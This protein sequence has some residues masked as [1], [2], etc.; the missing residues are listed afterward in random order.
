MVRVA[1]LDEED[2]PR[3]QPSSKSEEDTMMIHER[4]EHTEISI[5]TSQRIDEIIN[6][7]STWNSTR[8]MDPFAIQTEELDLQQQ[9]QQQEQPFTTIVFTPNN[10]H[11]NDENDSNTLRFFTTNSNTTLHK[12]HEEKPTSLVLEQEM[13]MPRDHTN[14]V[15]VT[16]KVHTLD[17]NLTH[18]SRDHDMILSHQEPQ[19]PSSFPTPAFSPLSILNWIQDKLH[20][21]SNPKGF[22]KSYLPPEVCLRIFHFVDHDQLFI[23]IRL[24][25]KQWRQIVEEEMFFMPVS[26]FYKI[27]QHELQRLKENH[28][29][30][31]TEHIPPPPST[32]VVELPT[33]DVKQNLLHFLLFKYTL[34]YYKTYSIGFKNFVQNTYLNFRAKEK[35]LNYKLPHP[36]TPPAK[37]FNQIGVSSDS[38]DFLFLKIMF[39]EFTSNEQQE[40]YSKILHQDSSNSDNDA[41]SYGDSP[42]DR[43]FS[44]ILEKKEIGFNWFEIYTKV[45]HEYH[46]FTQFMEER[47]TSL[48]QMYHITRMFYLPFAILLIIISMLL[49]LVKYLAIDNAI[50]DEMSYDS[51]T[52]PEFDYFWMFCFGLIII[53]VTILGNIPLTIMLRIFRDWIYIVEQFHIRE[54][55]KSKNIKFFYRVKKHVYIGEILRRALIHA[56]IFVVLLGIMISLCLQCM[57]LMFPLTISYHAFNNFQLSMSNYFMRETFGKGAVIMSPLFICAPFAAMSYFLLSNRVYTHYMLLS[58]NRYLCGMAFLFA[59]Y[60][61][62]CMLW[63]S[64]IS[65]DLYFKVLCVGSLILL[66]FFSSCIFA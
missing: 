47:S 17:S 62:F 26:T 41:L 27:L 2:S 9:R 65:M 48:D 10:H 11:T 21:N 5:N 39:F 57:R 18:S 56:G 51:L 16:Q 20:L 50:H 15:C 42:M 54:R 44:I 1:I 32:V 19:H 35:E 28:S 58:N 59:L 64:V 34:K 25:C 12:D 13:I 60:T 43:K 45:R 29:L 52:V 61:V 36:I 38:V 23:T 22:E 24:V 30:T 49:A 14:D 40:E 63:L 37:L 33:F 8:I 46:R 7:N 53:S 55:Y 66:V 3:I 6:T 4:A 31:Q